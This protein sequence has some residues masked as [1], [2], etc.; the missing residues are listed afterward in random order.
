MSGN[1]KPEKSYAKNDL[2]ISPRFKGADGKRAWDIRSTGPPNTNRLLE[3]ADIALGTKKPATK[4]TACTSI[5][6]T[7]K[8][9]PYTG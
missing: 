7:S 3:M 6:E 2:W 5:H 9:E 4:K 8:K 1:S